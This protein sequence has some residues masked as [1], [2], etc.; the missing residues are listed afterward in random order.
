VFFPDIHASFK[1]CT[2]IAGGKGR[3]FDH[4]D[5]AF[6]LHA[7]DE[8]DEPNRAFTLT[9]EDFA[10]LNPNTGTAPIFRTERDAEI[11]RRIY[12]KF[13]VL[14]DHEKGKVWPVKY[15]RMFDMTNDSGLFRTRTE[16]E[17]D[18]FYPVTKNQL[19]KGDETYLPLYEGKM[20]QM[21]D[22]RAASVVVNPANLNRPAQPE[23]TSLKQYDDPS[24]A[25]QSQYY[26]N[27][28]QI[29][30]YDE[31]KYY[32]GFKEIS[33]PTNR[34]T[35]I[36][37]L[38]PRC[39]V[40]NKIPLLV[41]DEG[42]EATYKDVAVLLLANLNA[43]VFD[44]IVRQKLHGQTLNLFIIE[45][46]PMIPPKV[47]LGKLGKTTIADFIKE[48]VLHLTY[49]AWDMEPF[50]KDMGYDGEPFVWDEEDRRHR[51][52]KLDALFFNLYGIGEDDASYILS[53]F[54]IIQKQDEK[55][56]GC[57]LTRDLILAYMRALKAG[58]TDVVVKP[59]ALATS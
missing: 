29:K 9:H 25:P 56:F 45:Q 39:G 27:D 49:T 48:H 24:F 14:H 2:Y 42:Q 30:I 40:G 33:A 19:K 58:D 7:V 20:V 8:I 11:T 5:M 26:I 15:L 16:L 17:D 35:M 31:L 55:E 44:F 54:P 3:S 52:A 37:V 41:P 1:F 34:R 23:S 43:F 51:K 38:L 22:H 10:R 28:A 18:G 13:P 21:Y 53:T 59:Q 32:L 6:F 12:E 4:T 50:A 46:L 47:F 57:Y 36:A